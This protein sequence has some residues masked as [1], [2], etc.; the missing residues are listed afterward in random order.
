MNGTG[1]AMDDVEGFRLYNLAAGQGHADALHFLGEYLYYF[2]SQFFFITFFYS[3][4][5]LS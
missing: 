2:Y 5:C 4:R 1:V 3:Y